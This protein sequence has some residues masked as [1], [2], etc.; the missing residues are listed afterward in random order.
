MNILVDIGHPAHVHLYRNFII[1]MQKRGHNLIV[2]EREK[3]CTKDLLDYY[4]IEYSSLVGH[5][6]NAY[7]IFQKFFMNFERTKKLY[8]IMKHNNIQFGFGVSDF[9]VAWAGRLNNCKS[10]IFTDSEPVNI[11]R[12]FTYPF[13]HVIITPQDFTRKLSPKKHVKVKSYKELAYLHPNWF[14]P[15]KDIF[16][17]LNISEND[18]YAILRFNAFGAGHDIGKVGFSLADKRNLVKKL[19]KYTNVFISSELELPD[20]LK[21]FQIHIPS[22][23]MHDALYFAKLLVCD[24]QTSTTEAACLG[25]PV[26][27]SNNWVGPNDMSNFIE[28]EKK[29]NLIYSIRDPKK[30]I[31]KAIEIIR[32]NGLKTEWKRKSKKLLMDK[33]DLTSFMIWFVVNYPESMKI[34]QNN[35]NFQNRFK[36][37]NF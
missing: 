35:P 12:Y 34:L 29:Y 22:H 33:I 9:P 18:T 10:I 24:T 19:Q 16:K 23:K 30:A 26:V 31:K 32:K 13:S 8:A 4:D 15:E 27:R 21:S 3:E 1:E 5:I 14:K 36:T 28:L 37:T 17:Y 7:A 25:T 6:G 2:T 20:D 11:D